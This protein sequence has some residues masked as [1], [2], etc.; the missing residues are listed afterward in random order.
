MTVT[1]L[2]A[3]TGD[4]TPD[5]RYRNTGPGVPAWNGNSYQIRYTEGDVSGY[6]EITGLTPSMTYYVAVYGVYPQNTTN[7][8]SR[9]G[10]EFSLD[11]GN[12]YSLVDNRGGS[13]INWVDN[14]TDLGVSQPT[15]NAGD[16]RF[17]SWIP[18]SGVSDASGNLDVYLRLPATLSDGTATDR[19][20]LDGFMLSTV[21]EPA[22]LAL[23][24]VGA[25]ALLFLR[26][27]R[28]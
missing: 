15:V 19:F 17:W 13:G 22:T 27:R 18:G 20:I 6:Q 11:G 9:Y 4:G 5:W 8:G 3:V 26:R 16:T 25:A 1:P 10:A 12:T 14:S 28:R 7:M 2:L 21:P 23:A 24:G